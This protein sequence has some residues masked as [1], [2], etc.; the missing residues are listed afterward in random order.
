MSTASLKTPRSHL[1]W[2]WGILAFFGL[3]AAGQLER[4]EPTGLPAFYVH[5]VLLVGYVL[6]HTTYKAWLQQLRRL[7]QKLPTLGW[8]SLGWVGAGLA[9]AAISN[10]SVTY[11]LMVLARFALYALAAC[12]LYFDLK[13]SA[14]KI[15][16]LFVRAAI[17]FF[18][19][20]LLYFGVLQYFLVPDTRFLFYMGWDYHY[21]RLISTIFDPGFTGLILA[22]GYLFIQ[23]SL[24]YI[25]PKLRKFA[26]ALSLAMV[27]GVLLTYSRASYLAFGV[28]IVFLVW[29]KWQSAQLKQACGQALLAVFF[30]AS[31]FFLPRPGG[32]GVRLERTSTIS[33]RT[34]A[35]EQSLR[36]VD[37]PTDLIIGQGL[38][39][40]LSVSS[41]SEYSGT[42]NHAKVAD[43]WMVALLAGTGVVGTVLAF[44]VLFQLLRWAMR[45][46]KS[47]LWIALLAVLVHGLFN[48]SITYPFIWII[49]LSWGVLTLES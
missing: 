16:P 26:V 21:Y 37:S 31:L 8:I 19:S 7:L 23:E 24:Q 43:N 46:P 4:I 10:H 49:L 5:D 45:K 42:L 11:S 29:K 40:P 36:T 28:I 39:V 18:F 48:A 6:W 27:G 3:L 15:Q 17:V 12:S 20:L 25:S 22:L 13:H 44:A 47:L 14:D 9:I 35:A 2:L 32:E 33:A 1:Y 34:S 30:V 38:F 41:V